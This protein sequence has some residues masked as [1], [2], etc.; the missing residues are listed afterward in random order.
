MIIYSY[1]ASRYSKLSK[2]VI[3]NSSNVVWNSAVGSVSCFIQNTLAGNCHGEWRLT[4]R[5]TVTKYDS[6]KCSENS[7][8]TWER[9]GVRREGERERKSKEREAWRHSKSNNYSLPSF[10]TWEKLSTTRQGTV[11]LFLGLVRMVKSRCEGM[12]SCI[13]G[14]INSPMGLPSIGKCLQWNNSHLQSGC[15]DL[16]RCEATGAR[17][18]THAFTR[19]LYTA[20]C[21]SFNCLWSLEPFLFYISRLTDCN[22]TVMYL[23]PIQRKQLSIRGIG[24]KSPVRVRLF[25]NT[26]KLTGQQASDYHQSSMSL[27]LCW[28]TVW[29][30][31]LFDDYFFS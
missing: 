4:Q 11:S 2:D 15:F 21:C 14:L 9:G 22:W 29:P 25:G 6:G 17:R 3:E 30:T 10:Y 7:F 13:I 5:Y 18:H 31:V 12:Q 19:T 27:K 28:Q 16:S 24:Y 26:C 20:Q 8:P 1:A 23:A